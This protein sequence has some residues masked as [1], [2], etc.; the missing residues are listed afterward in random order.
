MTQIK[1]VLNYHMVTRYWPIT[2]LNYVEEIDSLILTNTV[3]K[4]SFNR[5]MIKE[6]LFSWNIFRRS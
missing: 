6:G 2:S 5:D 1:I 3:L 4:V